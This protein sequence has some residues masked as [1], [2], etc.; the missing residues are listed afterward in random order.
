M[1]LWND[2]VVKDL[3]SLCPAK[4]IEQLNE[5]QLQQTRDMLT[6]ALKRHHDL[7]EEYQRECELMKVAMIQLK[8][9]MSS[10]CDELGKVYA[11]HRKAMERAISTAVAQPIIATNIN[12]PV[13]DKERREGIYI[14]RK[15]FRW[16]AGFATALL[17]A[18]LVVVALA[19]LT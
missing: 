5:R 6:E 8:T 11:S 14:S 2:S 18:S 7:L 15:A 12:C 10:A 1:S 3:W 19:L 4:N 9:V 17:L 13:A 16:Y